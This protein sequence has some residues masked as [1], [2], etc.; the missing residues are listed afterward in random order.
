[1]VGPVVQKQCNHAQL[2]C[3]IAKVA[4]ATAQTRRSEACLCR[5]LYPYSQ[6]LR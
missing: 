4:A 2:A 1:M 5:L 3:H 6:S